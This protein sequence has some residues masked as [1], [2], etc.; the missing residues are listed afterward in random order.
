[1]L[2]STETMPVP[3]RGSFDR[4]AEHLEQQ[5]RSVARIDEQQLAG[6]R[7]R[8]DRGARQRRRE[9]HVVQLD[10]AA[11]SLALLLARRKQLLGARVGDDQPTLRVGQQDRV[12][13]RVDDREEQRALAPE[14]AQLLGQAAAAANLIE[15]L[16]EYGRQP[17]DVAGDRRPG[18][19]QQQ[20][21]GLGVVLASCAA[22]RRGRRCRAPNPGKRPWPLSRPSRA[23]SAP[24]R[25]AR[26]QR[27]VPCRERRRGS[28]TSL[29]VTPKPAHPDEHAGIAV[30][31]QADGAPHAGVAGQPFEAGLRA[32]R[33]SSWWTRNTRAARGAPPLG[34]VRPRG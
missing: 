9:E 24:A 25:S 17:A 5:V 34:T 23:S 10:G 16:T 3:S 12:G 1:M 33:R 7:R 28:S 30:H 4:R 32:A 19:Q 6:L 15:L 2:R 8:L 21:D 22:G 13:D 31:G 20:A 11:A 18:R 27:I 29:T 14:L 26:D